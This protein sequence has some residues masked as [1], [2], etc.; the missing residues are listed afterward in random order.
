[1]GYNKTVYVPYEK[2]V[3]VNEY[4]ATTDESL[5]LLNEFK[6]KA[7]KD[8]VRSIKIDDN[9][10]L[11]ANIMFFDNIIEDN[12]KVS[13]RF[14]LNSK[15][16][17]IKTTI[18]MPLNPTRDFYSEVFLKMLFEEISKEITLELFN[19][20]KGILTKTFHKQY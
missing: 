7:E 13:V 19:Q 6:D 11:N 10:M 16:Y 5:K 17:L 4:R 15:E 9:Q 20:N 14:T 8:L 12:I 2:T 18:E 1:M 3:T